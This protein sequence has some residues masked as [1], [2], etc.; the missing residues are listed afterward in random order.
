MHDIV[1]TES[2]FTLMAMEFRKENCLEKREGIFG[3]KSV[4][5]ASFVRSFAD[6]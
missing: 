6:L 5:C 3:M 1:K 2:S 4:A